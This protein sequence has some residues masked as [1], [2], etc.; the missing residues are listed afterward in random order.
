LIFCIYL[1][2]AFGF[3]PVGGGRQIFTKIGKKQPYTK[4]ETVHKTVQKHGIHVQKTEDK[5]TK[6]TTN[7]KRIL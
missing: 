6:Q 4:E 2:A 7:I 1:D 5:N 3:A